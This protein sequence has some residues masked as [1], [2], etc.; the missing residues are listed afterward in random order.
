ME[1]LWH[2]VDVDDVASETYIWMKDLELQNNF[3][4]QFDL[5]K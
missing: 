3:L 2:G 4:S 1:H 5:S